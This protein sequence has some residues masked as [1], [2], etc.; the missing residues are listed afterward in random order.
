MEQIVINGGKPLG[1]SIEISGAKNAVLPLMATSILTD[2]TVVLKNT[3]DLADIETLSGVLSGHGTAI[4]KSDIT[5]YGFSLHLTTNEI[6]STTAPY[7]LVRTMRASVLVLGPLLA[8]MGEAKVSLPGGCAIG[9]RPVDLHIKVMEALGA[10]IEIEGGYIIATAKDGLKGAEYTFPIVSVGA[11]ENAV[12]A[13]VLADGTTVLK[14]SAQEPEITDLI[15]CLN[16][17]G[18]KITMEA[19]EIT[20]IGVNKLSGTTH[21]VLADRIEAGSFACIA[22]MMGAEITLNN[23]SPKILDVPLD[24]L[25]SIGASVSTTDNSITVKGGDIHPMDITTSPYPYFPT[26]LQAQYMAL[27]CVASGTSN[28]YEK[29]FENRFMHV[30]E[31]TRLGADIELDG[32]RAIIKGVANLTGA[33]VMATDLRAS[34]SLVIAGL[35]AKGTTKINRIYHLDRGY[36]G[37]E[38]KLSKIGADI[39]RVKL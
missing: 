1:G 37:L 15:D 33:E 23:I 13:G 35:Y 4:E 12:M 9:A 32:D 24:I 16:S 36:A 39:K 18:A 22:A 5:E 8:R 20:I 25:Q 27:L 11:T 3:P 10:T 38:N 14:N 26:D 2:E 17:M 28:I 6:T 29:V 7:E 19:D 34:M 31:L 21:T 30:P